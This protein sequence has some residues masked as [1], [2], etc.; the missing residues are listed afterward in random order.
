[1]KLEDAVGLLRRTLHTSSTITKPKLVQIAVSSGKW[2]TQWVKRLDFFFL[3]IKEIC[4]DV[5]QEQTETTNALIL[6]LDNTFRK[7][8][9]VISIHGDN[10][11]PTGQFLASYS[12][13]TCLNH[14]LDDLKRTLPTLYLCDSE[15]Q[16]SLPVFI[17]STSCFQSESFSVSS[18]SSWDLGFPFQTQ[19]S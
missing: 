11:N 19:Q 13:W 16:S 14:V 5:M 4:R 1:M 12:S 7:K 18:S 8:W 17:F 15:T 10:Q 9:K 2:V 3:P 6:K